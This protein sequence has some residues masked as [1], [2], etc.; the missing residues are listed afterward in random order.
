LSIKIFYDDI[1]ELL[2][3]VIGAYNKI[4]GDLNFIITSDQALKEINIEYLNHDYDTDVITFSYNENNYLNGEVYISIDT[5]RINSINY[6]VSL[7]NEL[8]RVMIHGLLHMIGFEDNSEEER[9]EM[10]KLEDHWLSGFNKGGNGLS[11]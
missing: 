8:I 7:K 2:E 10:R 11:I 3:E 5:V 9:N 6:N 1:K 4:S